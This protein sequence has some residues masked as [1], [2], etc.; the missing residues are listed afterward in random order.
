MGMKF[1]QFLNESRIQI[2]QQTYRD[3]MN[4][5][6][7]A[8]F[9]DL[10]R[11]IRV[12]GDEPDREFYNQLKAAKERYGD[13]DLHELSSN[14]PMLQNTIQFDTKSLPARYRKNI[15]TNALSLKL[16]AGPMGKDAHGGEYREK[17]KGR[18]ST[19]HVNTRGDNMEQAAYNSKL[20]K[21][22]LL[23]LEATVD[24]ELQHMVQD[25]A[26]GKLHSKQFPSSAEAASRE[27]DDDYLMADEE[28]L[29]I[30]TSLAQKFNAMQSD[31][32]VR[33]RFLNAVDPRRDAGPFKFFETLYRKDTQKWKKAV[34][35]F[36]R[37]VQS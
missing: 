29:P 30:I 35:E 10:L 6:A 23:N 27:G 18:A 36:H 33:E 28:F 24:H 14:A 17:A 8:Y 16:L 13:F 3:A 1:S 32:P 37:L 9:S 20:I 22:Q 4:T 7:S 11:L 2:P 31:V 5:V 34:K 21:S 25:V 12:D 19:I 26:L 15:K